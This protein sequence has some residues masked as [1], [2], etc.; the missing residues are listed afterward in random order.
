MS[1]TGPS[2]SSPGQGEHH[3]S[4]A[5]YIYVFVALCILTATSFLTYFDIWRSHVPAHF[6]W[7]FM[8]TVSCTKAA[9]VIL[10]FMHL[11]SEKSWKYVLT[12]PTA[13]MAVFLVLMLVPDVGR[14]VRNYSSERN[15]YTAF[16]ADTFPTHGDETGHLGPAKQ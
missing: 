9:L 10:F 7:A 4:K 14:R 6:G 12:I 15:L 8:M 5:V 3:D 2:H 1:D 11:K 13:M 16:P